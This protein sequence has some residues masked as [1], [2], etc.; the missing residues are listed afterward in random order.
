[1]KK[2]WETVRLKQFIYRNSELIIKTNSNQRDMY[3]ENIGIDIRAFRF[4]NYAIIIV[5]SD[6]AETIEYFPVYERISSVDKIMEDGIDVYFEYGYEDTPSTYIEA[7]NELEDFSEML[8]KYLNLNKKYE[9]DKLFL[10]I[11]QLV[12]NNYNK[13]EV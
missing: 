9:L 12:V 8:Y 2:D 11:D 5:D 13:I 3:G 4:A 6:C 1:M 7:G 10:K